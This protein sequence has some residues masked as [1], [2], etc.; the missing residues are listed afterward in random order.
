MQGGLGHYRK[1]ISIIPETRTNVTQ[2]TDCSEED[3]N[4]MSLGWS[5]R[6]DDDFTFPKKSHCC[7]FTEAKAASA[8]GGEHADEVK[9]LDGIQA[10]VRS[11]LKSRRAHPDQTVGTLR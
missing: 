6:R 4:T 11:L 8:G 1:E 10:I 9:P 3:G 5:T 7:H 2:A